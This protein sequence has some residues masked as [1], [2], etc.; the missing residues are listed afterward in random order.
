MG[1]TLS[2]G[3]GVHTV[4][5]LWGSH[6]QWCEWFTLS[7]VVGFT[8]SVMWVVGFTLSVMWVVGFTL[9]VVWVVGF[10]LSVGCGVH[11]VSGVSGSHCQWV[12]GFTLSVMWV[13]GFTLS[14]VWVAMYHDKELFYVSLS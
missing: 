14:V 9:S 6:C 11:T 13:V 2:V 3:C 7:L 1:F 5:G 8:L 4:S 12:V 10:T